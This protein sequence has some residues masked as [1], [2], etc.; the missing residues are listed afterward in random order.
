MIGERR[1]EWRSNYAT[2]IM[3][4]FAETAGSIRSGDY[5]PR[6]VIIGGQL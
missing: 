5:V 1:L 3:A 2:R 6:A 4:D